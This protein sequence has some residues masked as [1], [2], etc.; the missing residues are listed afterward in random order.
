MT[1]QDQ[2]D[3]IRI[4]YEEVANNGRLE[5]LDEM[6]CTDHVEHHP[7]PGQ[8]QGIEGFRQRV[9]MLRAA[10]SPHFTL[11]HVIAEDDKVAVMWRNQG[12]QLADWFGVPATGRSFDIEGV[13]IHSFRDGRLAEHWHVV[14]VFSMMIQL[15][16][17]PA[18]SGAS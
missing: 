3:L 16:G 5:L 17:I 18:P 11:Q 6:V 13:D 9:S 8:S 7:L 1:E 10:L 15:G 4:L 12:T 14:D 2:K